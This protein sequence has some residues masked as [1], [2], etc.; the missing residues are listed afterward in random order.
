M[1]ARGLGAFT[2][3]ARYALGMDEPKPKRKKSISPTMRTLA[4]LRAD[5]WT[6]AIVERWNPHAMIRQDLYGFCDILAVKSGA[7]TLAVQACVGASL[8]ARRTKLHAEPRVRTCIEAGWRVELWAWRKVGA[9]GKRKLW[10]VNV[11][12]VTL[13]GMSD[14]GRDSVR[15]T[16]AEEEAGTAR[17]GG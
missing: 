10:D 8:A 7:G 13:G 4:K 11:E 3:R 12:P 5:G 2:H 14:V 17:A 16:G 9:R 1:N 15:G 6:C